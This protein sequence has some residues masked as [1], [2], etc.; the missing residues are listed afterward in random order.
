MTISLRQ[1]FQFW[2][3]QAV[4]DRKIAD[5]HRHVSA[6]VSWEESLPNFAH[7]ALFLTEGDV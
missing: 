2:M 6:G 4:R 5:S 7:F 1:R 3:K